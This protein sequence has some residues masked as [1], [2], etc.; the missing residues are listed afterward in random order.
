MTLQTVGC[1]DDRTDGG[2]TISPLFPSKS[3]G[4][5]SVFSG[6]PSQQLAVHVIA[7]VTVIKP[8]MI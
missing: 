6:F 1:T 7:L 5:N 2:I 8:H 4:I 3:V